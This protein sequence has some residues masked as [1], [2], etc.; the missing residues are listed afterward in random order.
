MKRN[1][2]LGKSKRVLGIVMAAA[3]AMTGIPFPA[4]EVQASESAI[5]VS[6]LYG[7]ELDVTSRTNET[8]SIGNDDLTRTFEIENGK[9][10]TGTISNTLGGSEF[11]PAEGSEEFVIRTVGT[12]ETQVE[13][14]ELF[15]SVKNNSWSLTGNSV[16]P[17]DGGGYAAF[18][19]NDN[20]NSWYHSD[21][22]NNDAPQG[23]W[24]VQLTLDRG[25]VSEDTAFMTF[26]YRPRTGGASANGNIKEFYLFASDSAENLFSEDNKVTFANGEK[27]GSISMIGNYTDGNDSPE[28]IYVALKESCNA[29]YIGIE[30]KTSQNGQRFVSG[31]GLDL[32]KESFES[33]LP[34]TSG[35]D[36]KASDL[37]L[38]SVTSE[39]H[40]TEGGREGNE[41]YKEGKL[42]TFSFAPITWGETKDAVTIEEKVVMYQGDHYMR[43]WIELKFAEDADKTQRIAYIDGE[44]LFTTPSAEDLNAHR[45]A[46]A[47]K[48][49]D[50]IWTIPANSGGIVQM[51]EIRADLGQPVYINGM[52]MGSEFPAAQ[53]K[54]ELA[55]DTNTTEEGKRLAVAR[56]YT[57]KNLADL[58][59]DDHF[60][61]QLTDDN[62][63][64]SWQTVVGASRTDGSEQSIVQQDFYTYINDIKTPSEFRLQ[65]NS[66]Y[67]NMM[68]ITDD[69][70]ME[71]FKNTD[72]NFVKTGVRPLDSY[73]VDDGWNNYR[74]T[75]TQHNDGIGVERN[76]T[77][78]TINTTGF[79]AFNDKFPYEL[80]TS[81]T[82]VQN[83]GSYFGVWVGP[84][85][86]YNYYGSLADLIEAGVDVVDEETG[87]TTHVQYGSKSGGSIDVSDSRY[88]KKFAEMAI[89]WT[90][91]FKVNYWK[92]DG[93]ADN[94]QYNSF[95]KGSLETVGYSER[96][97]HMYGGPGGV[98]HASDHWEK[99]IYV[100]EQTRAAAEANGIDNLWFS[101]TCY[102]NPSPWFLQWA[103]SIWIQCT[104]D[105]GEIS[106]SVLNDKMNNMLTYRDATYYDFIINHEFQFPLSNLYNHEPIYGKEDTGINAN[107]MNGEQF[108]NYMFVQSGRGSA[109][110]ELYY[111]DSI[112]NDE[113][114]L[115]NADYLEW[116]EAH[117]ELLRHAIMIGGNPNTGT[118]LGNHGSAANQYAYG[119]SGF[120]ETEPEGIITMRNPANAVRTLEFTMDE[121]I[122]VR[123]D[124]EYTMWKE[125]TYVHNSSQTPATHMVNGVAATDN[126]LRKGDTVSITLQPGESQTWHLKEGG[127]TKAP[128]LD[129]MYFNDANTIQVRA[130]ERLYNEDITFTVSGNEVDAANVQKMADLRTFIITLDEAMTDGTDVTVATKGATDRAGNA[131]NASITNTYYTD[132]EVVYAK[133]LNNT[134]GMLS[135]ATRSIT[136]S[137]GFTVSAEV[138]YNQANV[139][140]VKQGEEYVL[141]INEDGQPYFTVKGL[142]ATAKTVMEEGK[143]YTLS[144]V[145]ENNDQVRIYVNGQISNAAY[146]ADN[147]GYVVDAD[148]ITYATGTN[149]VRGLTVNSVALAHD[150]VA[151]SALQ[152]LVNEIEANKG[153]YTTESW[154]AADMDKA[155]ADAKEAL[156]LSDEVK[157]AAAYEVLVVAYG[158]LVPNPVASKNYASGKTPTRGW[159]DGTAYDASYNSDRI[160][161]ATDG[162]K[163][164]ANNYTVV[165]KDGT[166]ANGAAKPSYMQLDLGYD[167]KIDQVN[168]WRYWADGRTYSATAVVVS[169]TP[170]FAEKEVLYYSHANVATEGTAATDSDIFNLGVQP[171]AKL[172][173]ETSTGKVLYQHTG[174]GDKVSARYVRLYVQGKNGAD[175]ENHIC[176]FEVLG[177]G[178][179]ID[180]YNLKDLQAVVDK[181][182]AEI[183][184]G[185]Y[186]K[187]SIDD[188]QT[189][190]DQAKELIKTGVPDGQGMAVVQN[191]IN[192]LE[193]KMAALVAN[194][195]VSFN[196]VGGDDTPETLTVVNGSTINTVLK[197]LDKTI[198]N[199]NKEGYEFL[200]WYLGDAKFDF[201]SMVTTDLVLEAKWKLLTWTIK[202]DCGEEGSLVADLHVKRGSVADAPAEPTREGYDFTG[203][204]LGDTDYDFTQAV[205][206]NI[207]LVAQWKIKT[208]TVTFNTDGGSEVEAQDIQYLGTVKEPETDPT[209]AEFNFA[210]W[211]LDGEE[212]DFTTPVKGDITLTA[213]WEAYPVVEAPTVN[214]EPGVV[215]EGTEIILDCATE[216]AKIYYTLETAPVE[217]PGT[218]EE[219]ATVSEEATLYDGN[220]IVVDVDT[221]IKAYATKAGYTTSETVTFEY[222]VAT[223]NVVVY[224]VSFND[225]DGTTPLASAKTVVA[226]ATVEAPA[227]PTKE[228]HTFVDWY[229]EDAEYDFT[230]AVTK[231]MVL[232]A[233][234]DKNV[235]TV[236]FNDPYVTAQEVEFE[237][238]ATTPEKT[239]VKEGYTFVGW[240]LGNEPYDFTTKVTKNLDLTAEWKQITYTVSFNNPYVLGQIVNYGDKVVEPKE[241]VGEEGKTFLG[242]FEKDAEG[243]FAAEAFDFD[244][245]LNADVVTGDKLDLFDQWKDTT[246]TV[247]FND[248]YMTSLTVK[249]GETFDEKALEVADREGYHFEGWY[250]NGE[251]Y[252]WTNAPLTSD[253]S[254]RAKWTP[255]YV[256]TIDNADGTEAK[257]QEVDHGK[258]ATK[259]ETEPSKEGYEFDGWFVEGAT[260]AYNFAAKVYSDIT[261]VAQY[262][263]L[264]TVSFNDPYVLGQVVRDGEKAEEPEKD[265][266]KE[267]FEFDYWQEVGTTTEYDFD[268]EVT[269]DLELEAKWTK[270]HT[271]SFN[272]PYILTQTVRDGENAT[273]PADPV[274][275]GYAFDG[276]KEDGATANFNFE[277]DVVTKD[278]NLKAQWKEIFTVAFNNAG[279]TVASA[280]VVDGDK[281]AAKDIPADPIMDN[282][283]FLGWFAPNA[284][285]AFNF[286]TDVVTS[287]LVLTAQWKL[288]IEV[289]DIEDEDMGKLDGVDE[290]EE[291]I[292]VSGIKDLTYNGAKQTQEFRVYDKNKKLVE[293]V[294]YTVSIKNNQKAYEFTETEKGYLDVIAEGNDAVNKHEQKTAIKKF[295][296][297]APQVVLKMKGTYTGTKNIYFQIKRADITSQSAD[298]AVVIG[299]KFVLDNLK[300]TAASKA[301]KPAV[302]LLWK[303][304]GKALKLN[305]DYEVVLT[306]D[307]G[308]EQAKVGK[309]TYTLTVTGIGNFA[310]EVVTTYEVVDAVALD[311]AKVKVNK[312][313]WNSENANLSNEDFAEI[314]I[315]EVKVKDKLALGKDYEVTNVTNK[316]SVGTGYLTINGIGNYVGSKTIA[317]TITGTAMS[318]VKAVELDKGYSYTGKAIEPLDKKVDDNLQIVYKSGSTNIP[319]TLTT[320]EVEGDYSVTYQKNTNKGTAT[321]ILTGNP[322]HGYTGTKKVTFKITEYDLSKENAVNV[323]LAEGMTNAN[324]KVE[325]TTGGATPK[326]VV[327]TPDERTLEEGKDYTLSY[328][329]NKKQ[330]KA[331]VTVKGKGN[332]AKNATADF[333]IVKK[334]VTEGSKVVTI[335]VKDK[336]EGTK[337]N[338]WKQSFKV[339]DINGKALGKKD[340]D[341]DAVYTVESVPQE[342]SEEIKAF[343]GKTPE[344]GTPIPAG[345]VM[346]V[347]VTLAGDN[348]E[349]TISETYRILSKDHDISKAT[350]KVAAKAY[351]GAFVELEEKDI[352]KAELK[353]SRVPTP[354]KYNVD[355]EIKGYE[356]N[357]NKGTAK[358][359]FVGKG[360][361]GGEKT[362][363]FKIG[364]RSVVENW[365]DAVVNTA[366]GIFN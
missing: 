163:T 12:P 70:I 292:W 211:A 216:D 121:T 97:Q 331:V 360:N 112:F 101:L 234:W 316:D 43:K 241:P 119:Y 310:G 69:N 219:P 27:V 72:K 146:D 170:D 66:W 171:S 148:K 264:H 239:P 315:K 194:Q 301:Q 175:T 122:G 89:D 196:S 151:A 346:K 20:V 222:T 46:N 176:E 195:T 324:G 98:Y 330:G 302:T 326:V 229:L 80:T 274:K 162:T 257:V 16:R 9:L 221:T 271:V 156:A 254:L 214:V 300:V 120:S 104:H 318:K 235:Y 4:S 295:M 275:E 238:V 115:I 140:L 51:D 348:Y 30:V 338:N 179:D 281:V 280:S 160:N 178:S 258:T 60:L 59:R 123:L 103:N 180:P 278:L 325:Y 220:P 165:G 207:T 266:V 269:K 361:F 209:K 345:S 150:E 34:E 65:Y 224:T 227:E 55:N 200:G 90:N 247:S 244:T 337:N 100:M 132:N 240:Y 78:G 102:T 182:E 136:G 71:A 187:D 161:Q 327:T 267:G 356:K 137:Q 87:E 86:G 312:V 173:A 299:E 168:L 47:D 93:F 246:Y 231:D 250:L 186:S 130:S 262:T 88:V 230:E 67:D 213:I 22:E 172:Y 279:V 256:V 159:V 358:V 45:P 29:R 311:K 236:S 177:Q 134:E 73:V 5:K 225:A 125:H 79:W 190:V 306:D 25:T 108:R 336:V 15:T 126:I 191:V 332:Y 189:S 174:D 14:P 155:L 233:K 39:T 203:W 226:D 75:A 297:K 117:Y 205:E 131:L 362:V 305:K 48:D 107:S 110:W 206:N 289:G 272:D 166:G 253:L 349:G 363:T 218:G 260:K 83:M 309:G 133:Q 35:I 355:Y 282:Y 298:G 319:L 32:F 153:G 284:T 288:N 277:T 44:H 294:D 291:L 18:L 339:L 335:S 157:K 351:T 82:F 261:L 245:A 58:E 154:T 19:E 3:I 96:N 359:T 197:E 293:G 322:K 317:Y 285:T 188:L 232:T 321:M 347:T 42:L 296:S 181:A 99:W 249:Y 17:S 228:G 248:P 138:T 223:D 204:K 116:A 198:Q 85:G 255:Y 77:A 41:G 84:R 149:T 1:F 53:N 37:D 304:T 52:F 2:F 74:Q 184:S 199:P 68:R 259:P 208:Y 164:D 303:E 81:S 33:V 142:T 36:I 352:T 313:T 106:N 243:A 283:T 6:G 141:G 91:R 49:K 139:E 286:E 7:N 215:A 10:K 341:K 343:V 287:D 242:W 127:E 333:E 340:F 11:T 344:A 183:E 167:V 237:G 128:V 320:D 76:G 314:V 270:L 365:W 217:E 21:Y 38:V 124:K 31:S 144:G 61:N 50:I 92:W 329:N 105:R 95:A 111:S 28:W 143:T 366:R 334:V 252:T 192:D 202:F 169:D 57:G 307:K 251:P 265:P 268:T 201:D 56:Y 26:G 94:A 263:K 135:G 308:E 364:A 63:Y 64:V 354:L 129:K 350:F 62:K 342:A 290:L 276:W 109:F 147:L 54:I 210:G 13:K 40:V 158:K 114:Y 353:I 323:T 8:I 23:K 145:R 24:P 118:T 185:R 193:T 357:T 212:Y 328:K 152:K 273:K 113:K